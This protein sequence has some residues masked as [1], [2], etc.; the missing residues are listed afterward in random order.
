[1][2]AA[3][4]GG[5]ILV[6]LGIGVTA[7]GA[8]GTTHARAAAPAATAT[9]PTTAPT[10]SWCA[11]LSASSQVR[12]LTSAMTDLTRSPGAAGPVARIK[13][14]G[15]ELVAIGRAPGAPTAAL[16]AAGRDLD[17]L[18]TG[19]PSATAIR[20]ASTALTTLGTKVQAACG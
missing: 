16:D 1:M 14:A 11:Q 20:T 9:D 18:T 4:L 15:A 12:A 2:R 5:P 8:C 19:T 17:A 13:A 7:L 10:T 3:R 6:A